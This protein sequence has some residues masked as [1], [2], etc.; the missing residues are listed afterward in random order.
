[1]QGEERARFERIQ[2]YLRADPGLKPRYLNA[3]RITRHFRL[4]AFYEMTPRCNLWCEGCYYFE[5]GHDANRREEHDLDAWEAFFRAEGER[6]VSMAYF[7]GAEPAL[8]QERLAIAAKHLK[9][10]QIGSNG[11]IRIDPEIPYRIGVSVW[12][13]DEQTDRELRGGSVFRKA[14][15][16]Y[17]GDR[18]AILL[19][20]ITPR[21]IPGIRAIA[22]IARDNDLRL[23]FNMYSPSSGYIDKLQSSAPRDGRFFRVSS[24]ESNLVFDSESLTAVRRAVESAMT[25]FPQTVVYA[26]A[27]NR[28]MTEPGPRYDIDRA[29]GVAR[30]CGSRIVGNFTYFT[31]DL[32]PARVKC[33]TSSVDCRQCRMYSGGWST[34]FEPKADDVSSRESFV[35]WLDMLETLG[36]IFFY[37][38]P[39]FDRSARPAELVSA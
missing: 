19:Y 16:N 1:M 28:W 34:R 12:A 15:R 3:R 6:G 35:E 4:P 11:T 8:V 29:T 25:D 20:T 21:N 33:C 17:A 23:T 13:G 10:G 30:D 24:P 22:E 32:Q 27:Y 37:Q 14:V 18:R 36:R 38:K 9:I 39:A 2:Q 26:S 31:T 5:G 7:V